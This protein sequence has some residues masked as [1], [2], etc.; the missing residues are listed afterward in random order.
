MIVRKLSD[1]LGAVGV[2]LTLSASPGLAEERNSAEAFAGLEYDG[3]IRVDELDIDQRQGDLVALLE[4]KLSRRALET[5]NAS[6]TLGY[7]FSQ[8]SHFE[9][10]DLNRQSHRALV[11]GKLQ[12]GPAQVSAAYDLVHFRLGGARLVDIQGLEP[13]F[14]IPIASRTG[15]SVSYRYE[16]WDFANA[17]GR[18]AHGHLIGGAVTRALA[19]GLQ[20]TVGARGETQDALE[21]RFDFDGFQINAA[22]RGTVSL[23]GRRG[24]A[25]LEYSRR[26]R[27]Y[28][29]TTP[30]IG[31]RRREDRDVLTATAD[32]PFSKELGFRTALRFTDR[33]SNF[34]A[35]NYEEL[36]VSAGLV[37]RR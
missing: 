15:I 29:S 17:N 13:K 26:E 22:M 16:R 11:D 6:V 30:S 12:L 28:D 37:V 18:D 24:A 1:V 21:P 31:E 33:N 3:R 35:S 5:G 4:A 27:R 36:R 9:F 23:L 32:V 19:N 25:G 10:P 20:L 7:D 14:S 2:V 8:R 34:P